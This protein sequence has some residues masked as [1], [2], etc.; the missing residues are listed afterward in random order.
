MSFTLGKKARQA[1][2]DGSKNSTMVTGAFFGP[3]TA[4]RGRMSASTGP[5][6]TFG[7]GSPATDQLKSMAPPVNASAD[8][9]RVATT[10]KRLFMISASFG[11]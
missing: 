9:T 11:K 7:A 3:M 8:T 4:E 1:S 10:P 6:I 2:H 5:A